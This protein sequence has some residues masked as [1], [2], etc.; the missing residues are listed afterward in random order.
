MARLDQIK[1]RVRLARV[2]RLGLKRVLQREKPR[3]LLLDLIGGEHQKSCRLLPTS[4]SEIWRRLA[5]L[6]GQIASLFHKQPRPL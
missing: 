2:L 6:R 1:H 3:S 4:I 5:E